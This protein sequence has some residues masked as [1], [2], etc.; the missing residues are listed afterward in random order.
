MLN[1]ERANVNGSGISPGHP[2]GTT[3]TRQVV[4]IMHE[5]IRRRDSLGLASLCA[6]GGMRY[7]LF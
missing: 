4:T 5:M 2:V 1:R 7:A 6:G 3:G